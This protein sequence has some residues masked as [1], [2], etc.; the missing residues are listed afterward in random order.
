[1]KIIETS[2]ELNKAE[3]YMLTKSPV[4]KT[5]KECEGEVVKVSVW[6]RYTDINQRGNETELLAFMS[7][8]NKIYATNSQTFMK[9]FQDVVDIFGEDM[10]P[11]TILK[12]VSK[13]NKEFVNCAYI[14]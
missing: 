5:V 8:D 6:C 1:M 9:S 14:P 4:I 3:I 13:N 7:E 2:K 12:G 11:I 10:P